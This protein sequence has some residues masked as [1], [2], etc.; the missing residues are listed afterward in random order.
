MSKQKNIAIIPAR[1]GSKR[2]PRKNIKDFLGKAIIA[3]SIEAAIESKLFDEVMVSTDD[4]E[5]AEVAKK[6]GANVPFMRSKKKA[7]DYTGLADVVIEVIEEY[8]KKNIEY[9]N[10]C[11]L[12]ATAPFITGKELINSYN[13]LIDTN[14]DSVFPVVRYSFP[15][16]RAMQFDGEKIKM[17]WPENLTKRSQDLKPSFHDAG[18][19]YWIKTHALINERKFWTDNTTAIEINE[20]TAQDIDTLEDW[21]IAELKYKLING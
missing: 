17:I 7:D 20:Q 19:F 9:D 6:H 4:R 11:C 2:I 1:G 10:V 13:K 18:L 5:I 14:F 15:I 12:L 3:Y 16:Q 8:K 21:G